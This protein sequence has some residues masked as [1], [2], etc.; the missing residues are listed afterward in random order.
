MPPGRSSPNTCLAHGE[1]AVS[2]AILIINVI[3]ITSPLLLPG[4]SPAESEG[5]ACAACARPVQEARGPWLE[6]S[7]C[8]SEEGTLT[9]RPPVSARDSQHALCQAPLRIARAHTRVLL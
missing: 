6:P 3:V 1:P 4:E 2:A 8:I 7:V 5:A 9:R